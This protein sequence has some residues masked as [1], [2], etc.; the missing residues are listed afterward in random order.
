[1]LGGFGVVLQHHALSF[2][3]AISRRG[4]GP[5][6]RLLRF[7]VWGTMPLG[8]LAGGALGTRIGLRPALWVAAIGALF[9][10]LPIL[11]S[12]VPR[13]R[14]MP[15]RSRPTKRRGRTSRTAH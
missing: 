11:L 13:I 14:A 3:Q 15:S 12:P 1:M 9:T 5:H 6:Q 10:F 8:A 7:L 4:Y 2:L